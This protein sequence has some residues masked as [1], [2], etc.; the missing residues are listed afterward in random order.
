MSKGPGNPSSSGSGSPARGNDLEPAGFI[1]KLRERKIIQTSAAFLAGGWLVVEIAHSRMA[2][3]NA[4]H[5]LA[6][7]LECGKLFGCHFNSQKPL[8]FDQDPMD[9]LDDQP[10]SGQERR[11]RL[12]DLPFSELFDKARR[13]GIIPVRGRA[14]PR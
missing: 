12:D 4:Y 6:Q 13:L 7:V 10:A 1:E 9:D 11:R 5:D 3:L 8:R 14:A 2:G